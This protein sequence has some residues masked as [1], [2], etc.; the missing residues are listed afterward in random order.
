MQSALP[1]RTQRALAHAVAVA[2]AVSLALTGCQSD[3]EKIAAYMAAGRQAAEAGDHAEATI[4]F[5]KALQADPNLAEA[6]Y[7]LANS[8]FATQKLREAL[9]EY[10][11]AVRLDPDNLEARLKL[12]SLA[13][14][15]KDFEETYQQAQA[16]I[17]ERPEDAAAHL[18]LGQA[19]A[20]LGRADE[21]EDAFLRCVELKPEEPGYLVVLANLYSQTGRRD[22]AEELFV[23]ITEVKP[24]HEAFELLGRFLAED[25]GRRDE[26]FDVFKMAIEKA[27]PEKVAG[28]YK[29]LAT[30]LAST[31]RRDEAIALIEEARAA[32]DDDP[33]GEVQL[34][35]LQAQ[36]YSR[37]DRDEQAFALYEEAVQLTPDDPNV[38]LQLSGVRGSNGDLAGALAA[39]RTATEVAPADERAQ[40]RTAE[41]LAEIAALND[42]PELLTEALELT[43][44]ILAETPTHGPA[45]FV[46]GRIELARKDAA[47]AVP[48]LQ[49][50]VEASPG[51][52]RAYFVLGSARALTGDNS[53]ARADVSRALEL[54]GTISDARRL[55]ALLHASLGE[56][57]Y[58]V[59]EGRT[60]LNRNPDPEIRLLVAKSLANL[61]R[62]EEA[63]DAARRI[64]DGRSSVAVLTDRAR[65]F[66]VI[67]ELDQAEALLE[68]A[69]ERAPE[70]PG[71]LA[72][73]LRVDAARGN[74]ERAGAR[75]QAAAAA[76]PESAEHA[77]LLG[78]YML[79]KGDTAAAEDALRRAIELDSTNVAAYRQLAA[80]YERSERVGEAIETY[81]AALAESPGSAQIHYVL[82]S[83]YQAEG[84]SE[85]AI[86][87]LEKA[88][89][90]DPQLAEAKND[91]AYL[92]AESGGNLER[93]LDLAQ[94]TKAA[95]PDSPGAADTLGWVLYRRGIPSAAVG[96]LREAVA[97]LEPGT[98]EMGITRHHLALAYEA[99]EQKQL[100]I[101]QLELALSE[102]ESR[103]AKQKAAGDEPEKPEWSEPARQMLS[104]LEGAGAAG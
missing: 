11:E 81:Q 4:E 57:E 44:A 8:Y 6:H 89:E 91:L 75:I 27:P 32:I 61:G 10:S 48:Y 87:A 5:R 88:I 21:A 45:L 36:I 43:D 34:M 33:A 83:L 49:R 30:L 97:G 85:E 101:E 59:E 50:A 99:N 64:P 56:Y 17:G 47:A 95:M 73:L 42:Q 37:T 16:I 70:D 3:E 82:G 28:I 26:A 13:L 25:P 23:K 90:L 74:L 1:P 71:V 68:R 54:D 20:A 100:A 51:W 93:A 53:A 35:Y 46:R 103:Q 29:E 14:V 19:A 86:S 18:L 102:L 40:L 104:R 12:G 52:A 63:L 77:R 15:G 39:S 66:L 60:Y 67:D 80:V 78:T 65:V 84:R 58:A 98:P 76:N 92:L 38:H 55:L 22:D 41:L 7:E 62:K 24:G 2:T 94:E 79:R 72:L 31:D 69:A 96:Y 9:W